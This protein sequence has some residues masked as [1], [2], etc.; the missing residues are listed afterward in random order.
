MVVWPK[1]CKSRSSLGIYPEAGSRKEPAS[2]FATP[3][4]PEPN[5]PGVFLAHRKPRTHQR[6]R[7]MYCNP[8]GAIAPPMPDTAPMNRILPRC[9]AATLVLFAATAT[10]E[11]G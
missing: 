9:L 4:T 1:Q 5:A 6:G 2:S 10:A 3:E 8:R 11:P 7:R